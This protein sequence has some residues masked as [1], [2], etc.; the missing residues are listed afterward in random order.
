MLGRGTFG[1]CFA[2]VLRGY[3]GAGYRRDP[4]DVAVKLMY[5]DRMREHEGNVKFMREIEVMTLEHPAI[6]SLVAWGLY[7]D[8]YCLVMRR[9]QMDLGKLLNQADAPATTRSIVALGI[10]AGMEFLHSKGVTH[11]DLKPGNVFISPEGRPFVADFG[12]ARF[13]TVTEMSSTPGT[14]WYAAPEL[15]SAGPYNQSVDVYA[16][17]LVFWRLVTNRDLYVEAVEP[18]MFNQSYVMKKVAAGKRPDATLIHDPAQRNLIE[19]CWS[20]EASER[21]TFTKILEHPEI[22]I[23]EGCDQA[24]FDAYRHEILNVR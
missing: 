7:D 18:K 12:N 14:C 20:G 13:L 2:G 16:W 15:F 10:A 3:E 4:M 9:M 21:P 17:G 8:K 5:S 11:R 22:L 1:T 19:S 6:L 24:Q 23:I